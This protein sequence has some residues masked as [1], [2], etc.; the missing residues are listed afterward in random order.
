MSPLWAARVATN[1]GPVFI[2]VWPGNRLLISQSFDDKTFGALRKAVLTPTPNKATTSFNHELL[3]GL[4]DSPTFSAFQERVGEEL[5]E[6]VAQ[7]VIH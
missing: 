7:E 3:M 5:L 2:E 1:E 6:R 4:Y